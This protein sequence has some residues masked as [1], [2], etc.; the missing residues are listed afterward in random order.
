MCSSDQ[1]HSWE[2]GDCI[3]DYREWFC[4]WLVWFR[5]ESVCVSVI[6][7][8]DWSSLVPGHK[9]W[10]WYTIIYYCKWSITY[11]A[12]C[13]YNQTCWHRSCA[14]P[15]VGV[16]SLEPFPCV[17]FSLVQH[18]NIVYQKWISDSA[19]FEKLYAL[20][21]TTPCYFT[22]A[23]LSEFLNM[24]KLQDPSA[25]CMIF[26]IIIFSAAL[27]GRTSPLHKW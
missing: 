26:V 5:R 20:S 19:V 9:Y 12:P 23:T 7:T 27:G 15:E 16:T 6:V 11:W 21:D 4:S 2:E 17:C 14:L 25:G 18:G 13:M 8:V 3:S 24:R 10:G 1:W 22:K